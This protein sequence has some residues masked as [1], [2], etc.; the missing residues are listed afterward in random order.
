MEPTRVSAAA[1]SDGT[2]V[3][4]YTT[5]DD[6][7]VIRYMNSDGTLAGPATVLGQGGGAEI[8]ADAD[9]FISVSWVTYDQSSDTLKVLLRR[10]EPVDVRPPATR[11][12]SGP[13]ARTL[14]TIAT[15][16]HASSETGSTFR[17]KLDAKPYRTCRS[18]IT[19][20]GIR[21]GRHTYRVYAVDEAGQADTTPAR[22]VWT[23]KARR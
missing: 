8:A 21:R 5:P 10:Y 3:M 4:A 11:I 2:I 18:T 9:G 7:L 13:P 1:L 20:R 12:V 17:C 23:V 6:D 14:R 15:F 22:R 19:Y 16:R